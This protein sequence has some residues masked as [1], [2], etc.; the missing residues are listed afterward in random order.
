MQSRMIRDRGR[1]VSVMLA[2]T[3]GAGLPDE[4]LPASV[5]SSND[6]ARRYIA[7]ILE[8]HFLSQTPFSR[9]Y[10]AR[11]GWIGT[12]SADDSTPR[13]WKPGMSW[14]ICE[15]VGSD[16]ASSEACASMIFSIL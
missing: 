6:R 11:P 14:A 8:S 5:R 13:F 4:R 16:L 3:L 1:G 9:M 15:K 7:A 10:L 2:S 12:R